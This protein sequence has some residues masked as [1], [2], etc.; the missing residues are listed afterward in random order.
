MK[1]RR[2]E[3]KHALVEASPSFLCPSILN[4]VMSVPYIRAKC[5]FPATQANQ[6]EPARW[7]FRRKISRLVRVSPDQI[8]SRLQKKGLLALVEKPY[9][10]AKVDSIKAEIREIYKEHGIA[11]GADSSLEPTRDP[12]AVRILIEVYKQ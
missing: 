9:D 10:Q 6:R 1:L 8:E 2:R 5:E 3:V 12:R 4:P 7:R 11:E